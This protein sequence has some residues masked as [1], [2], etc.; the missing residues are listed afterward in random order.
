MIRTT[1]AIACLMMLAAGMAKADGVPYDSGLTT[2][3][4]PVLIVPRSGLDTSNYFY[5]PLLDSWPEADTF[6]CSL[7]ARE[8]TSVWLK[9]NPSRDGIWGCDI[10]CFTP[11]DSVAYFAIC[12]E[13]WLKAQGFRCPSAGEDSVRV[14]PLPWVRK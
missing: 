11:P 14:A 13:C 4:H 9:L 3:E 12:Y 1:I 8:F 6:T 2:T 7:C 5:R 10:G